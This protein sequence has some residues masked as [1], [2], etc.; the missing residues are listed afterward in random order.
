MVT[1]PRTVDPACNKTMVIFG[2][3]ASHSLSN[4]SA[5]LYIT[6]TSRITRYISSASWRYYHPLSTRASSLRSASSLPRPPDKLII[7]HVRELPR[8]SHLL[9]IDIILHDRAPH[10][11]Q[12]VEVI[13]CRV[14]V[15][16]PAAR[17]QPSRGP[18]QAWALYVVVS[19]PIG[20]SIRSGRGY[21]RLVVRDDVADGLLKLNG[22]VRGLRA[23]LEVVFPRQH[24]QPAIVKGL[25]RGSVQS[26]LA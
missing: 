22:P 24:G 4:I 6:D 18:D 25:L 7:A 1:L 10:H 2:K 13:V 12:R 19:M 23:L 11:D 21:I 17:G 3:Q 16:V 26:H 20:R 14:G 15:P 5:C 9:P 8:P